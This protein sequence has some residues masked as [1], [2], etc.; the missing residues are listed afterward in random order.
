MSVQTPPRN[1]TAPHDVSDEHGVDP[2]DPGPARSEGPVL[3]DVVIVAA[4]AAL[5]AAAA[6]WMAAGVFDD[7]LARAVA[8]GGALVGAGSVALSYRLRRPSAIQYLALPLAAVLGALVVIPETTG[9][10]ANLPS[11]VT[12][13]LFSGGLSQPPVPFDPGWTFLLTVASTLL[14][15]GAASVA[16]GFDRPNLAVLVPVPLVFAGALAQPPGAE[17]LSVVVAFVLVVA[18][19]AVA[20]GVELA[21]SGVSSGRFEIRRLARGAGAVA[22]LAVGLVALANLASFLLPE[23]RTDE[24]IPPQRPETAPPQTDRELFTVEADRVLP[25][26]LGVLDVYEDGAWK[27]PPFD[28]NR[29]VDL[30]GGG[31]VPDVAGDLDDATTVTFE[32]SDLPG[33]V[34]PVLAEPHEIDPDDDLTIMYDP[35]TQTLRFPELTPPGLRYTVTAPAPPTTDDLTAASAP[36]S[37]MEP[38]MAA[39]PP[40]PEVAVLLS[41][42]PR[43][44]LFSR[45]QF[46][47]Q[48]YYQEVVAAGSGE[49]VD[50]PPERV[51][52][53]LEGREATPY[54]I[55]AGEALLARW[56]GVPARIGY[57][58]FGGQRDGPDEPYAVH[59][60]QG[61][62]WLEVHFGGEGWV[63]IVGKPPR[64]KSSLSDAD[65]QEDASVRPTDELALITYVPVRLESITLLFETV[66]FYALQALPVALGSLLLLVFYPVGLRLLRRTRRRRWADRSG[67]R[68]RVAVAYT[69]L[70]DVAWDLNIGHP[71][72][73]PLE[74]LGELTPDDEHRELAWLVTRALWGDL[75]RDI[76]PEDAD[77]AESMAGSVL[78]RLRAAEAT[79]GRILA[80]ASRSSLR[81]P[82]SDELP[83][84][85]PGWS[86]R[87][88]LG[89]TGRRL[90]RAVSTGRIGR[91]IPR[92]A[93]AGTTLLVLVALSASGC[94]EPVD[95]RSVSS[96]SALPEPAVPDEIDGV[97]FVREGSAEVPFEEAGEEALVDR[98]HVYSVHR[99]DAI[100]ASLQLAQFKPGLHDRQDDVRDGILQS[101]GGGQFEPTRLGGQ[102]VSV[103]ETAEQRL[104]LWFSPDGSHYQLMVARRAFEDAGQLFGAVLSFQ[105]GDDVGGIDQDERIADLDPRRGIP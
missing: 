20:Y 76:G 75:A 31:E 25:W 30:E 40:P 21:R 81:E 10:S 58:Y 54:E 86:L 15:S 27:L 49:P 88:A 92:R 28:V 32:I 41:D 7:V 17:L 68:G 50:V 6:G 2:G 94:A 1:E 34:L 59:P 11:L 47:R 48:A 77:T 57:G 85:W 91:L 12:E 96:A 51:A 5:S 45:L 66:R 97:R 24:V 53:I 13:A 16:L 79:S 29:F 65:K 78:R 89:R 62:T 23:A 80:A 35:R 99:E 72:Q 100:E 52:E 4:A 19:L 39:P 102:Q 95:L 70:R 71:S 103:L 33:R 3:R 82:Y 42:A 93:G 64:A 98:G 44:D 67:P 36:S 105:R 83:N 101:L 38:F 61:A 73:T 55:T 43:D 74:F 90:R 9:G 22:L 87:G 84:M 46:V 26:R 60:E 104:F 56:A 18:A 37:D 63:P 69:E 14:G 8:V